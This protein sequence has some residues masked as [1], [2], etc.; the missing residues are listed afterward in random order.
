MHLRRSALTAL[1]SGVMLLVAAPAM[2]DP[3]QPSNYR[4]SVDSSPDARIEVSIQGGDAYFV[5]EV[6]PGT[7]V[8]VPGYDDDEDFSDWQEL[9]VYLRVLADGTV[10]LNRSSEAYYAN[11]SRYGAAA[12]GEVGPDVAPD[13]ETVATDGR[14]AWHDHRIH[15]MSPLPPQQVDTDADEP[16]RVNDYLV[17]VVIDGELVVV[18]G[19]LDYVADRSPLPVLLLA[20]LGLVSGALLGRRDVRLA[21]GLALLTGGTVTALLVAAGVGRAAGFDLAAPPVALAGVGAVAPL[22][23]ATVGS[24]AEGQRKALILLGAGALVV[25]GVLSTGALDQL[26]GGQDG[27]F[28]SWWLRPTLPVDVAPALLRYAMAAATG[29]GLGILATQLITPL[30]EG[31]P[32]IDGV[33]QG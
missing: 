11:A 2:A 27:G 6:E 7:E 13:W 21:A 32:I 31:E 1:L 28:G 3:A 19:E 23:G 16:Q 14:V 29:V 5:L 12:P 33:S 24:L 25:F 4:S 8:V 10:Q 17:P 15:W 26:V 30:D 20:V 22:L 18:E 9:E